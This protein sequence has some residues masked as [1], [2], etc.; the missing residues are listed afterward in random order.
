MLQGANT[1]P[2]LRPSA[3]LHIVDRKL[4]FP[5]NT[6][7]MEDAMNVERSDTQSHHGAQAQ[8]KATNGCD[9]IGRK[10]ARKRQRD[11]NDGND[12]L[13]TT[14]P[15]KRI[16]DN[17]SYADIHIAE[18]RALPVSRPKASIAKPSI[19]SPRAQFLYDS[20]ERCRMI[21]RKILQNSEHKH[22][23]PDGFTRHSRPP[24]EALGRRDNMGVSVPFLTLTTAPDEDDETLGPAPAAGETFYLH[25]EN[26]WPKATPGDSDNRHWSAGQHRVVTRQDYEAAGAAKLVAQWERE[27][28]ASVLKGTSGANPAGLSL[29]GPYSANGSGGSSP[30]GHA[31]PKGRAISPFSRLRQPKGG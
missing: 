7:A 26:L 6:N 10:S 11:D 23:R 1:L 19:S 22:N 25:D 30:V 9:T 18:R 14:S 8:A 4:V 5:T 24:R 31:A 29:W 16:F 12:A 17:E 20:A 27:A 13:S 2:P 3:A 28:Y 15:K 21:Q